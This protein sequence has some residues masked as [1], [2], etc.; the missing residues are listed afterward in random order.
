[1]NINRTPFT[2]LSALGEINGDIHHAVDPVERRGRIVFAHGYKGFK[3]W[4]AWDLLGDT[5]AEEG[6]DFVRF[7]FSH[8]GHIKPNLLDCSD[9]TAWSHNTYSMELSDLES[10][11]EF[12]RDGML[13][14]SEQLIVMGHSRG[15][16]IASLAASRNDVDGLVLLASVCDFESRFPSGE[17]LNTWRSSDRLE[18]LNG[19]TMQVLSHSFTF[20]EDFLENSESLNIESAI[21]SLTSPLLV[22][23]GDSDEAV[24]ISD[25]EKL[26]GWANDGKL[27]VI[28]GAAHTFGASHPWESAELPPYTIDMVQA[29]KQFLAKF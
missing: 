22:I 13:T 23:H 16:G 21:R 29:I 12:A 8:N 7:N 26:A 10:V 24:D 15:G 2:H 1:M 20:Y 6:W 11:L 9:E 4:G 5:L 18:V 25:G 3:D 28:P 14:D 17:A 19:R 27:I